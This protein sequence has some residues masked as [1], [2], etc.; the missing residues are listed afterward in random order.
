[1][2]PDQVRLLVA[3]MHSLGVTELFVTA[4]AMARTPADDGTEVISFYDCMRDGLVL[5]LREPA[6]VVDGEVATLEIEP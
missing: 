5:R 2:T 4:E 1:M 3:L 6:P